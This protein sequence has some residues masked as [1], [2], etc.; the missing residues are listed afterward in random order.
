MFFGRHVFLEVCQ[1]G[2]AS[3][4]VGFEPVKVPCNL[5]SRLVLR[6]RQRMRIRLKACSVMRSF[7]LDVHVWNRRIRRK[8]HGMR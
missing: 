3:L 2:I 5:V 1:V 8:R 6:S 4:S 7:T